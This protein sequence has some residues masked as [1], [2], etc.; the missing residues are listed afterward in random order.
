MKQTHFFKMSDLGDVAS[1]LW[2][3]GQ[4]DNDAQK[5]DKDCKIRFAYNKG[6]NE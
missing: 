1:D 2:S 3:I 4:A 5:D 6:S